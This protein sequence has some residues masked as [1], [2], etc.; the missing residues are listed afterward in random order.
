MVDFI[1]SLE[2]IIIALSVVIDEPIKN[3]IVIVSIVS[4]IA[5]IGVYGIV[6]LIVR[7]DDMGLVLLTKGKLKITKMFGQ[8]LVKSLPIIIKILIV[9]K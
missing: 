9:V 6:A 5:T 2:I 1:L 8:L 3:Q 7:L 4:I